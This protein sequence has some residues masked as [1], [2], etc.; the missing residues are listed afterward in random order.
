MKSVK[1]VDVVISAVAFQNILDQSKILEAIKEAGNVK[2]HLYF[3]VFL[4]LFHVHY[5]P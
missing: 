4:F 5:F 3:I 2:V 1:Q